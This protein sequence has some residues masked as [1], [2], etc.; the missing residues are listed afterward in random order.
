MVGMT[1]SAR[2]L[3][4][5]ATGAALA[6]GAAGA[7][8]QGLPASVPTTG[9]AAGPATTVSSA[10]AVRAGQPLRVT[11]AGGLLT[12]RADDSSLNGILREVSRQTGMK[13]TGGV[14]E[15]RVYGTYGPARPETVLDALLMGT[16]SNML[17]KE[18]TADTPMELVLT[19][20]QGGATPPGPASYAHRGGGGEDD[21]PPQQ[22]DP[23]GGNRRENSVPMP[24]NAQT[25]QPAPAAAATP[26]TT[27]TPAATT[28][29]QSPNG[30]KT[31]QQIYDQLM[32]LQQQKAATPPQ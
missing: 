29:Q 32:K 3:G 21:L 13:V 5:M 16:G 17:L 19:P 20:R 27:G 25:I 28:D 7:L 26:D 6:M 30:V 22:M 10:S 18:N 12:V 15:E 2:L 9:A 8:G 11:W 14:V 4:G 31:P 23:R 24:F 1:G